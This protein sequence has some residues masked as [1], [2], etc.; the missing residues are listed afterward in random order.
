MNSWATLILTAAVDPALA[1][2]AA[3]ELRERLAGAGLLAP[4]ERR[5]RTRP[6]AARVAQARAAAGK[7]R[8]LSELVGEG[9][10]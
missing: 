3:E 7:G 6:N 5:D 10:S 4:L 1:G 8:M 2:S 9:R